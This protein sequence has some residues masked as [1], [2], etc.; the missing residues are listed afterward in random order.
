MRRLRNKWYAVLKIKT[1]CHVWDLWKLARFY[2]ELLLL[3]PP[4]PSNLPGTALLSGFQSSRGALSKTALSK[5]GFIYR[6]QQL[7][8]PDCP[9]LPEMTVGLPY[10]WAEVA[11]QT[12]IFKSRATNVFW[13]Q[14]VAYCTP[15]VLLIL[16]SILQIDFHVQSVFVHDLN[17]LI[18]TAFSL[19]IWSDRLLHPDVSYKWHNSNKTAVSRMVINRYSTRQQYH[20]GVLRVL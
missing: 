19:I 15:Y 9:E 8:R 5:C 4:D 6:P 3:C 16:R 10:L 20:S 7:H 14:A 2:K 12:C 13:H 11:R 17:D 1:I 18:S